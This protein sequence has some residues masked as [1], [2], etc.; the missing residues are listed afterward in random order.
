MFIRPMFA[1]VAA[2]CLLQPSTAQM[3]DW[4]SPNAIKVLKANVVIKQTIDISVDVAGT[5]KVLNP[6]ERGAIVAAT[7]TVIEIDS[8]RTRAEL[9]RLELDVKSADIA[10]TLQEKEREL[11][12]LELEDKEKANRRTAG[13]ITESEIRRLKL[14]LAQAVAKYEKANADKKA[15]EADVNVKK[16]ELIGY[17]RKAEFGGIVTD[18]H[19]RAVGASVRPGEPI[20]TIVNY[21][22]M[23][24]SMEISPDSEDK[25][26]V[27]DTVLIRRDRTAGSPAIR[28]TD[29]PSNDNNNNAG[30]VGKF[31]LGANHDAFPG[32]QLLTR[33]RSIL[34]SAPVQAPIIFVGKV[35][36]TVGKRTVQ[37]GRP[38]IEAVVENKMVAPGKYL[39][40][41]G[42]KIQAVIIPAR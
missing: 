3:P 17:T 24:V 6:S 42:T 33:P 8:D 5:I 12:E 18:L 2:F 16:A 21:D 38:T 36:M 14:T 20:M 25:I 10:I 22:R 9:N 7:Q 27:G 29:E 23:L 15:A 40:N 4:N 35:T 39:L 31:G 11:A 1:A 30:G 19:N 41:E 13:L 37:D 32:R 26:F 28:S 34:T